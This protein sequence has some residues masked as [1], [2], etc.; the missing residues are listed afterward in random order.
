M[1]ISMPIDN[2][3][4]ASEVE[5]RPLFMQRAFVA[6]ASPGHVL[7][8]LDFKNAFNTVRRDSIFEV[9]ADKVP[10]ILPYVTS[11]YESPS[12]L[13]HGSF[14]LLSSEGVQ[15]GDPLGPLLFSLAI[16]E[17]LNRIECVFA[18]GYL[19]DITLGDTVEV[20]G[21]EVRLFKHE[22]ERLGLVLNESK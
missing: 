22:A 20:L 10:E 21:D 5:Q 6:A 12:S 17:A 14:T 11:S 1:L 3:E 9:V 8:K 2:W 7:V 13:R 16:S 18:A 15:Q 4:L 19:D